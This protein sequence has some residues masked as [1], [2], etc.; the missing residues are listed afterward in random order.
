MTRP[1]S[2]IAMDGFLGARSCAKLG[3]R[4][5]SCA[6]NASKP[7]PV[8]SDESRTAIEATAEALYGGSLRDFAND[9]K[10]FATELRQAGD[11]AAAA[12]VATLP[13][14]TLSA[15]LVNRLWRQARP[16]FD[17]MFD[18]AAQIRGG[19]LEA[20]PEQ[21]TALARLRSLASEAL[22][23]D[24]HAAAEGTLTRTSTTLQALAAVGSFAPD[25]P[26]RLVADRDP[27]GFES[28]TGVSLGGP[29]DA[30]L[31]RNTPRNTRAA[32]PER[33]Q[34]KAAAERVVAERAAADRAAAQRAAAERTLERERARAELTNLE[35]V[36]EQARRDEQ[37]RSE[38]TE[39]L[40]IALQRAEAALVEARSR[41]QAS[42]RLAAEARARLDELSR[43]PKPSR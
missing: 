8:I 30:M 33:A 34:G 19:R 27:P 38:A 25:P 4:T 15:W 29:S 10:R 6:V 20:V 3:C 12:A 23:A 32:D 43:D 17:A 5:K 39:N 7:S 18:A 1:V 40:R 13:R 2:S 41:A 16:E 9:R 14:P 35:R 42:T 22:R 24:G 36:A 26:G 21:R 31:N 37:A 28:M 11:R